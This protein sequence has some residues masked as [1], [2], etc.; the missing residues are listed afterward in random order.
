MRV[1]FEVAICDRGLSSESD[2]RELTS[3]A[4]SGL[5]LLCQWTC[6][7]METVSWKLLNP[8]CHREN[9]ECPDNAEEYERATK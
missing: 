8:T 6:H 9:P 7:V 1:E 5:Q 2:N 3:L 4:L